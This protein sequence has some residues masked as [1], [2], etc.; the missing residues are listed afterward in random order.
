MR[1]INVKK[2]SKKVILKNDKKKINE[3]N[4]IWKKMKDEEWIKVE[5]K[6]KDIIIDE[7]GKK[8]NVNVD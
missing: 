2:E 3:K 1:E 6:M 4:K 5:V 7:Y 8:K